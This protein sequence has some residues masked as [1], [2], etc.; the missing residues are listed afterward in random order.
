MSGKGQSNS[1]RVRNPEPTSPNS[2]PA[3]NHVTM[4]AL[5]SVLEEHKS[6][7]HAAFDSSITTLESKLDSMKAS[8]VDHGQRPVSLEANAN[9]VS[10]RAEALETTCAVLTEANAK[11][12]AKVLD[13]ESRSKCWNIS[14]WTLSGKA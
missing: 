14:R 3:G 13:L 7:L 1:S 9:L 10:D 6:S 11:L 2:D 5:R 12:R 4:S 8:I